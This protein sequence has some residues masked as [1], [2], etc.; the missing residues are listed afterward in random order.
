MLKFSEANSKIRKTAKALGLKA[1]RCF[2]FDLLAG[3]D[4][5]FARDCQSWA[6]FD[7]KRL[8]VQDGENTEFRCYAA[9]LEILYPALYWRHREN[10]ETVRRILKQRGQS[11]LVRELNKALD[12]QAELVRAHSN[13]GDF[14]S[15]AYYQTWLELA[16]IRPD[17]RFYFYTKA[18][19]LLL[20]EGLDNPQE[21]GVRNNVYYTA[22]YGGTHDE[23]IS[24]YGLRYADVIYRE[25]D[26][27]LEIDRDDTHEAT[28][29]G[30]FHLLIHG[31]QP[32][33]SEAM[34]AVVALSK[35][36]DI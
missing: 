26:A 24:I 15:L 33:G 21:G 9:S 32:K 4:C 35:G 12:P 20:K 1:S 17:C 6:N 28:L 13:G 14:F 19:P 25:S 23:M 3:W 16:E 18:I 29:G 8:T 30:S 27:T 5:P 2:S 7:G 36:G 34:R 22:S 11:R 31:V 10:S